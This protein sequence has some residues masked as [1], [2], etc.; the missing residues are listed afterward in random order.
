MRELRV[1]LGAEQIQKETL[2]VYDQKTYMPSRVMGLAPF[3]H[4]DNALAVSSHW[5]TWRLDLGSMIFK[6]T[7]PGGTLVD[8]DGDGTFETVH[9]GGGFSDVRVVD[10]DG[11]ELWRRSA[12]WKKEDFTANSMSVGDLDGDGMA[13][14][15]VASKSGLYCI[16]IE[17]KTLW[18]KDGGGT[19]WDVRVL[20]P[21][22][23]GVSE[24]VVVAWVKI[25]SDGSRRIEIR[26]RLGNLVSEFQ[27]P[28]YVSADLEL[29]PWPAD[30]AID[31]HDTF[32]IVDRNRS[33]L[34]VM[35][36]SG[37]VQWAYQFPREMEMSGHSLTTSFIR[38][39]ESGPEYLAVLFGTWSGWDRS[40]LCIFSLD[41]ELVYQEVLRSSWAMTDGV[42][43]GHPDGAERVLYVGTSRKPEIYMYRMR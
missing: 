30:A 23:D 26:D 4:D 13:E 36:P 1:V 22:R 17:G 21:G 39:R 14:F 34:F 28:E 7:G 27:P 2:L 20:E 12:S 3:P 10:D 5:H 37:V 8:I 11:R 32:R 9:E 25:K 16:D 29:L 42:L 38:F 40:A 24:G 15:Y 6:V 19:Y 35:N 33:C 18:K 31:D 43:P 41:G